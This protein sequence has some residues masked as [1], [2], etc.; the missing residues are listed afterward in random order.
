METEVK[1]VG[2]ERGWTVSAYLLLAALAL[3]AF[4]IYK[5]VL[6]GETWDKYGVKHVSMFR[7]AFD[8]F[9][10]GTTKLINEE[11]DTVGLNM[12]D[13]LL[14]TR[15]LDILRNVMVKDFNNFVD[16]SLLIASNSPLEK[17][18]FFLNGQDW[19]RIRHVT[20]PSFSTGKL[21]Q[22]SGHLNESAARLARV[23][24]EYAQRDDLV[25][26]KHLMGQFTSEVIARTAFSLNTDCVGKGDDEFTRYAKKI[27]KIHGVLMN[28]L[29]LIM[30][31]NKRLH[32]FLVKTMKLQLVDS[33]S[34][35]ADQYFV[36][37]LE[38]AL[39]ERHELASQGK[40]PHPD[41]FQ[42]LIVAQEAGSKAEENS[43]DN[44]A[45]TSGEKIPRTMT[46]EELLGQSM[47]IIFAGFDTTASTLQMCFYYL[48]KHPEIQE[49]VYQE[50]TRTVTSESP[51]YEDVAQL[52]Y[53]E[54]VLN[55]TLRLCP[56]AP[57][58][59]RRAAEARTYGS[60]T[61]PKDAAVIILLD[62]IMRDPKHYPDPD[63][64][65]PERFSEENC[66]KRDP[67]AFV[68]FGYGPRQCI[69]M[70]LAYMELKFC[71]VHVM[72]KVKFELNERTEPKPG[73]EITMSFQ[74]V[75]IIDKPI[76][77]A[78]KLRES[79]K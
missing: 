24:E 67:M 29:M 40:K 61:I 43:T 38:S 33:V 8:D 42:N 12:G 10:K 55:E 6:T 66:A 50:I 27:F 52:R 72:R 30:F 65:D 26:I 74:G 68:P 20:T 77:L 45:G 23:L 39:K 56:P 71:L 13:M 19:R 2:A 57:I 49:K 59:T 58:M 14:L 48:A 51:T 18:L 41:L 35:D 32:R 11:G 7:I 79:S 34:E 73:G 22:V 1:G 44:S 46:H 64:F 37:I 31:Q 63:K 15:D 21:K 16:R 3:A 25:P 69:G 4:V 36:S 9:R 54:Q 5:L 53:T 70:R 47:L 78:V 76:M 28:L 17:G 75:V 62:M 60:V